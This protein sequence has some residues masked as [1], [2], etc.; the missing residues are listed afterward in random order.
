MASGRYVY[1]ASHWL[2]I[3]RVI[4]RVEYSWRIRQFESWNRV[5]KL[6]SELDFVKFRIGIGDFT[7]E[8]GYEDW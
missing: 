4:N 3:D 5:G 8:V 6:P 1:R 2:R 7:S